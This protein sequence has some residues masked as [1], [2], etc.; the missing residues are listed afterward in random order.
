MPM[1]DFRTATR[2]LFALTF[3]A[4]GVIGLVSGTFAP[5]WDQVPKSTPA[6]ELLAYFSTFIT[7][8]CGAGLLAKRTRT[9]AALGLTSFLILWTAAFK[10]PFI[11]RGPLVEGSYQYNGESWVLIAA[12]WA[13]YAEFAKSSKFPAGVMG[14]RIAYA[15]YGLALIA[16]GFSHFFYLDMT[17]PLIPAWL[18]GPPVFWA[19]LTGSLWLLAGFALVAGFAVRLAALLSAIEIA[20]ITLLV[21]GPMV[22]AGSMSAGRW[23]ETVVSWALTASALVVAASLDGRPWFGAATGSPP[24]TGWLRRP[25]PQGR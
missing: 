1:I 20:L 16:F 8:A 4:I 12:A 18:P 9:V 3:V 23:T 15:L 5:I 13:L 6:R 22:L 7:L 10:F 19:Y 11:V 25:S 2:L 21:W 14:L 17:T 24:A